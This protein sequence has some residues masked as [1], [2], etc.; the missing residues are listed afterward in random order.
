MKIFGPFHQFRSQKN[1][2]TWQN[3]EKSNDPI[4]GVV[5][6]KATGWVNEQTL[7]QGILTATAGGLTSTSI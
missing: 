1:L 3:S 4:P 5:P 2:A 7:F 6:G